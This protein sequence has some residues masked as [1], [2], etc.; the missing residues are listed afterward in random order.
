[1]LLIIEIIKNVRQILDDFVNFSA[2]L[3]RF[4]VGLHC[5]ANEKSYSLAIKLKGLLN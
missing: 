1:M 2:K 4:Q 5:N 3:H